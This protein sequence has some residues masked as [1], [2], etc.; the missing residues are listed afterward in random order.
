MSILAPSFD[1]KTF[2]S[3]IDHVF[4][5]PLL[6]QSYPDR[7]EERKMNVALC[8]SIINAA[9]D[10]LEFLPPSETPLWMRMIKMI[11]L[12]RRSETAPF[13]KVDLQRV[14]SEMV[15]GGMYR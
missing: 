3:V 7:Q 9:Q 8:D 5:P 14:L 10:F 1:H 13:T 4:M 15:I 11:E 12:T 2:R 6:P